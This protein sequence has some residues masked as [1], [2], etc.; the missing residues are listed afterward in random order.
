MR[1]Q[2]CRKHI[3]KTGKLCHLKPET[4]KEVQKVLD[5][6]YEHPEVSDLSTDAAEALMK[7]P[8]PEIQQK[9][10]SAVGKT[11]N[12][13][14]PTGG[15]IKKRLTKP[16]VQKVIKKVSPPEIVKKEP[17]VLHP[18]LKPAEEPE[19]KATSPYQ[20]PEGSIEVTD[21]PPQPSLAEQQAAKLCTHSGNRGNAPRRCDIHGVDCAGDTP[22]CKRYATEPEEPGIIPFTP[23]KPKPAPCMSGLP[24]PDGKDHKAGKKCALWDQV[25]GQFYKDE[26]KL[27]ALARKEAA[28]EFAPA[29]KPSVVLTQKQ[30][31]AEKAIARDNAA[32]A[33]L[34]IAPSWC[35]NVIEDAVRDDPKT[36]PTQ[37]D[38]MTAALLLFSERKKA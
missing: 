37:S 12:R 6:C 10:I 24:C 26:C 19:K 36:Y 14:T 18:N 4:I 33:W 38:A 5:F 25:I 7:I 2:E 13:K 1:S 15:T 32:T 22:D 23:P 34:A 16:E 8:D 35:R 31:D 21:D 29:N 20:P 11:L 27:D 9:A 3:E 17:A 30:K 28:L